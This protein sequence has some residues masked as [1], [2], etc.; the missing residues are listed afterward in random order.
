[1]RVKVEEPG[2]LLYV[3]G[4][5]PLGGG[6]RPVVRIS[7]EELNPGLELNAK[8]FMKANQLQMFKVMPSLKILQTQ[9]LNLGNDPVEALACTYLNANKEVS[10]EMFFMVKNKRGYTIQFMAA[11]EVFDQN[12]P[13]FNDVMHTLRIE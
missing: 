8:E 9:T 6:Q 5:A 11:K 3:A 10:S 7:V 13:A 4:P 1:E 2:V 12:K